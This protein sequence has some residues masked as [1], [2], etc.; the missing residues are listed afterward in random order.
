MTQQETGAAAPKP[1]SLL[2]R[3]IETDRVYFEM[4]ARIEALPGAELAWMPGLSAM[5]AGAVVQRI[6][7]SAANSIG[8]LEHLENSLL[9][10]GASMARIYPDHVVDAELF[11]SAGYQCRD[12]LFFAS[13]SLPDAEP[14]LAL[15]P[16]ITDQDWQDKLRFHHAVGLTPDGHP[17]HPAD[18]AQLEQRKCG[19]GMEAF[20]VESDGLAVGAI[21][22]IWFDGLLRI[23]NVIVHPNH[24]RQ[25]VARAMLSL[26]ASLG[27]TRGSP[28]LCLVAVR[29]EPGEQLYHK[30][31]MQM[32]GMQ[33]EWSKRLDSP[34]RAAPAADQSD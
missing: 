28:E 16:I 15:R 13:S 4:G 5:P 11:R 24:R 17:N 18:W 8:W 25:S 2:A 12:E 19:R 9:D 6:D 26:M 29:G 32:I 14:G 23:K 22:A 31:G 30:C 20:L 3:A 1:V 10:V 21:G 33:V 27:R 7:P 34:Q